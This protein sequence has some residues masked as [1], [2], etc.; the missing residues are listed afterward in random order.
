MQRDSKTSHLLSARYPLLRQHST[1][2]LLT[3]AIQRYNHLAAERNVARAAEYKA[4]V[5]SFTPDQIRI[6]N[7]ARS[8][9]R[10]KL[11]PLKSGSKHAHTT[12]L[13]DERQVKRPVNA[14]IYFCGQRNASSDFTGIS[15]GERSKLISGE[16]KALTANEKRVRWPDV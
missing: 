1:R 12:Q 6:A 16:W 14:W 13:V 5:E 4:W 2:E 9:L 11:P 8:Q 10:K 15:I 7:N 3:N